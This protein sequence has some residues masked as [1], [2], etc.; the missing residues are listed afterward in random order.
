MDWIASFSRL[1]VLC[2]MSLYRG[3]GRA[4]GPPFDC[5]SKI[6][7][8]ALLPGMETSAEPEERGHL[9]PDIREPGVPP[10]SRA[11]V[12][13]HPGKLGTLLGLFIHGEDSAGGSPRWLHSPRQTRLSTPLSTWVQPPGT[14][15]RADADSFPVSPAMPEMSHL[16]R[17]PSIQSPPTAKDP[18]ATSLPRFYPTL[19]VFPLPPV[20]Y[21]VFAVNHKMDHVTRTFTL[22]IKVA[23]PDGKVAPRH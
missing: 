19:R 14:R 16:S 4:R 5:F 18:M 17:S 3:H 21:R 6:W 11:A 23:S 15:P 20:Q 1:E 8:R 9:S 22:D 12:H 7:P 2:Q 13:H 10:T